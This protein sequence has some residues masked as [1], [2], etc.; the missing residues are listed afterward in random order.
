MNLAY[1]ILAHHQPAQLE[2]LVDRLSQANAYFFIHVDKK[3]K[4]KEAIRQRFAGNQHVTVICNNEVNWMGFT[5][6]DAEL[7]LMKLAFNSGIKF[8]YYV[9][10]S[11]QDY[12]IKSNA[13]INEFFSKHDYDFLSYNKISYMKQEFR[14]KHT[15]WHFRD[16]PYINPRNP[17]K[18]RLLTYLYFGTH[19]HLSKYLPARR[20]YKDMDTYFGSQWFALTQDTIMYILEFVEQNKGF[21]KS[22]KNSDGPDETF[23][24]TI[25]MNSPRKTNVV[26]YARFESWLTTRKDNEL[27]NPVFGSLR[28]MDW[29]EHLKSKPAVLDNAYVSELRGSEHLFARKFDEKASAELMDYLDENVLG[30]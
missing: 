12:P 7:D 6:I 20:F 9:L 29:S 4:D 26:D 2:R 14:N 13:Y 10:L 5:T 18:I 17:K 15:R 3:S 11:G 25:I 27:F 21:I 30:K 22:M 28:Y 16:I 24:H 1:M 23:F 19:I 8:K